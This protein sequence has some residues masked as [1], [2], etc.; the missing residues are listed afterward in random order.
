M[1]YSIKIVD[2]HHIVDM[3]HKPSDI[4]IAFQNAV[5]HYADAIKVVADG[6]HEKWGMK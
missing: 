6:I 2:G 1:N 3:S 4:K 5:K